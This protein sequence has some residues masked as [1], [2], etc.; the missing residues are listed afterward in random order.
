MNLYFWGSIWEKEKLRGMLEV[1]PSN[2]FHSLEVKVSTI[3][4]HYITPGI[5]LKTNLRRLN[6]MTE[7]GWTR[8]ADHHKDHLFLPCQTG[9]EIEGQSLTHVNCSKNQRFRWCFFCVTPEFFCV[10]MPKC[11]FS[12][13]QKTPRKYA[14]SFT[15][16]IG[17]YLYNSLGFLDGGLHIQSEELKFQ[18]GR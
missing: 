6:P 17:S 2:R 18:G 1:L 13:V 4:H 10:G 12:L 14:Y 15:V 5:P 8:F 11:Y 16:K 9:R 7:S 3:H